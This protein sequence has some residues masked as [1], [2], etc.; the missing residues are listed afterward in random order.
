MFFAVA[1][2]KWIV[3]VPVA[4]EARAR[5]T[6]AVLERKTGADYRVVRVKVVR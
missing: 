3:S 5:A 4:S 6:M 2:G 1:R